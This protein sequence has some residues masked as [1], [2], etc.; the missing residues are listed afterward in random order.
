LSGWALRSLSGQCY[1]KNCLENLLLRRKFFGFKLLV[2][3]GT[4]L[5]NTAFTT[6]EKKH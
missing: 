5:T 4:R 6:K 3:R 2:T 1:E